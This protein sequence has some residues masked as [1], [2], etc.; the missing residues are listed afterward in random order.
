MTFTDADLACPDEGRL[1]THIAEADPAVADHVA[2]C[3]TCAERLDTM[4]ADARVAARAIS[5][6]DTDTS[7]VDVEAAWAARPRPVTPLRS[8]R[9]TSTSITAV[10]ASFV[11]LLVAV[12]VA[13]TPT[14]R[15]AAADFLAQFRSEKLTVVTFDPAAPTAGLEKLGD[16]AA[17]DV[18]EGDSGPVANPDEAADVAGFTPRGVGVLPDGAQA[19]QLMAAAPSTAR[20]TFDADQAPDLPDELDGAQLVIHAPGAVVAQYTIG[21]GM[22]MVA[23]SGELAVDAEGADLAA[24]RDYVLNRP[25]VPKDLA[26]QLLAIDDW[27]ATLPI[28]VP[29]DDVAWRDTTVAGNPGLVIEDTMGSGLVWHADDR[30]HAVGGT[31][32][33][34]DELRQVADGIG[35]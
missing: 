8:R 35:G 1:R 4:C 5:T 23:E 13:V 21:D 15:Q 33:G 16:I 7:P 17:V 14:G 26:R 11:A 27:T 29:L 30:I 25:E 3:T 9:P 32:I 34:V 20:V 22:L 2:T 10:A 24:V 6:L 18:D 31:G 19:G 28:P 12:L